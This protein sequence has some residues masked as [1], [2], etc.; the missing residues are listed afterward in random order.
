M[1]YANE[2]KIDKYYVY[3]AFLPNRHRPNRVPIFKN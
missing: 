2:E 1:N 3:T